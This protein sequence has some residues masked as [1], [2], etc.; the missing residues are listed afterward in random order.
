LVKKHRKIEK[1]QIIVKKKER[2][3]N[4]RQLKNLFTKQ[5]KVEKKLMFATMFEK[6]KVI[7]Q[8]RQQGYWLR[9]MIKEVETVDFIK[10]PKV[11]V[12]KRQR[13]LTT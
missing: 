4:F 1:I 12:K 8:Q 2:R 5:K 3:L 13:I 9:R 7:Y 11:L 10:R 6:L